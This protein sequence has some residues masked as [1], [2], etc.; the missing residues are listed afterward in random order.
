MQGQ[1]LQD[2][3]VLLVNGG[4]LSSLH[5]IRGAREMVLGTDPV[6]LLASHTLCA[7]RAEF[8]TSKCVRC[9]A[10]LGKVAKMS[11]QH[12]ETAFVAVNLNSLSSAEVMSE[13]E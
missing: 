11:H 3:P 2:F 12:P 1:Q 8:W 7:M 5:K 6:P 9:P 4:I 10:A 13:D